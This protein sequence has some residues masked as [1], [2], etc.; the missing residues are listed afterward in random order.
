MYRPGRVEV[1]RNTEPRQRGEAV[2]GGCK[3]PD[4]ASERQFKLV[5][6]DPRQM[7]EEHLR[8]W[9]REKYVPKFRNGT[10]VLSWASTTGVLPFLC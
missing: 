1:A 7:R 2:S 10:L 4:Q 3:P 5:T 6:S 8:E 9:V